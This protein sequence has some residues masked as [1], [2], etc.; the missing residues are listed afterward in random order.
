MD[1]RNPL[2]ESIKNVI[3]QIRWEDPK[4]GFVVMGEI[5]PYERLGPFEQKYKIGD[6]GKCNYVFSSIEELED[7]FEKLG[8][9]IGRTI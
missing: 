3:Q 9:I 8:T 6:G 2:P 7:F 5:Q 4:S 1:Q